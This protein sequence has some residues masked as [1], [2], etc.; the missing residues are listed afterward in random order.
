MVFHSAVILYLGEGDRDRF[1]DLM[2]ELVSSGTC[3]WVSNEVHG[4]LPRVDGGLKAPAGHFVLGLDG[5]PRAF[6]HQHGRRL[7]WL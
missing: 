2:T 3:H 1:H 7:D 5:V 6:A 4:V